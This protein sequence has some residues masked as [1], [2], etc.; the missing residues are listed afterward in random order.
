MT[1]PSVTEL[2]RRLEPTSIDTFLGGDPRPLARVVPLHSRERDPARRSPRP[3]PRPRRPLRP[4]GDPGP[5]G[6]AA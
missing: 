2:P 5:G 3:R 1:T 4:S 6:D